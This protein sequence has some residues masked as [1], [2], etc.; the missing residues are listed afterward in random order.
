[1]WKSSASLPNPACNINTLHLPA[2]LGEG[3]GVS[4]QKETCQHLAHGGEGVGRDAG[5]F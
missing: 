5:A 4:K 2:T 1:M 3:K